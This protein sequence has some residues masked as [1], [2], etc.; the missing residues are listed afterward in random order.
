MDLQDVAEEVELEQK[1]TII[2]TDNVNLFAS[3][4]LNISEDSIYWQDVEP[5]FMDERPP[6]ALYFDYPNHSNKFIDLSRTDLY[7]KVDIVG[8]DGQSIDQKMVT[9]TNQGGTPR[10][11]PPP[12][13]ANP[14][15]FILQTMWKNVEIKFNG[16]SVYD[17]QQNYGYNAFFQYLL[18]TTAQTRAYQGSF[19]GWSGDNRNFDSTH[20]NRP[21]INNGLVIRR[22]WRM[23][24]PVGGVGTPPIPKQ[25]SAV[26]YYG[27]IFAGICNQERYLLNNVRIE[28]DFQPAKDSFRLMT[29]DTETPA[30]LKIVEAKLKVCTVQLDSR[31][32]VSVDNC[33]S[34]KD[35]LALYPLQK[36]IVRTF[37]ANKGAMQ[38]FENDMFRG[39]VPTKLVVGMVSEQAYHGAYDKNPFY[40]QTFNVSQIAVRLG[41]NSV[42]TKPLQLNFKDSDYLLGL[43]SLYRVANK[44]VRDSDIGIDRDNYRQGLSLFG[45][46]ID[47]G[48][49]E[50]AGLIGKPKYDLLQLVINFSKGLEEGVMVILYATFP[51]EVDV[52]KARVARVLS[53]IPS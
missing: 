52:D 21:P 14:V 13:E 11:L 32:K 45:F 18:G 33:M 50:S 48:S 43:I 38:F 36:S 6:Q 37:R 19:M 22:N 25:L 5:S 35:Q 8:E 15:E 41:N 53:D 40:F 10:V 1:E 20:P 17:A 29:T 28:V 49:H 42:P 27:P 4:Y 9:V 44:G 24:I 26:E 34:M 2:L 51:D 23:A 12:F 30:Y 39:K 46:N 3:R 31:V 47:P 16:F 7:L